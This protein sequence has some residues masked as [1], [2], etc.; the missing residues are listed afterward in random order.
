V[1]SPDAGITDTARLTEARGLERP[2][3]TGISVCLP[4]IAPPVSAAQNGFV[5][6]N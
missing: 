6:P 3:Q 5:V 4:R 1:P 2:R